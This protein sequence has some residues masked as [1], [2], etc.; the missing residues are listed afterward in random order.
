VLTDYAFKPLTVQ[1]VIA[2]QVAHLNQNGLIEQKRYRKGSRGT[3][4]RFLIEKYYNGELET[5][6][7]QSKCG[8]D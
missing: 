3:K 4:D 2:E 7:R 8:V 6:T 5:K 1:P